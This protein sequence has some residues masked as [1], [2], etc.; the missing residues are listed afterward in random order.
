MKEIGRTK[1]GNVLV[2][3][4][5]DEAREFER[6][7]EAIEGQFDVSFNFGPANFSFNQD[8]STVFG[9]I[10]AFYTSKFA[11]NKLKSILEDFDK[12]LMNQ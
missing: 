6:L 2:E 3:M 9:T 8:Y 11:V 5:S 4:S 10:R 12:Q 1:E 7:G